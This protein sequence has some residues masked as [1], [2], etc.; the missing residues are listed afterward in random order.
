MTAT[1]SAT[2]LQIDDDLAR[3]NAL[4]LAAAQALG[5]ANAS[6][7]ISLGGLTGVYLLGDDKSLATLP[8]TAM[9]L[10]IAA[11]ALPAG[12]L[13]RRVGRR[14]GFITGAGIGFL[15]AVGATLAVVAGSFAL[16]C[17]ASFFSGIYGAFVHQ[18]RFAAADTASERFKPKAISWVMAGGILA[19]IIGPQTVIHTKDLLSPLMFAGAYV[20]QA[21]L[22]IL[23]IGVLAFLKMP[24]LPEVQRRVSGRPILTIMRQRDF[25]IAATSGICAYA[26]MNYVMTAAPLAM[27]EC[28]FTAADAALGIQWHILAMFGPSFFTGSLIAR[29]GKV[30]IVTIGFIMLAGCGV[31]ALQGIELAHFWGALILLGFGWNFAFIGATAMV[32]DTYR[33]E[34]RN[35]VQAANDF[36]V[37]GFVAIASLASGKTLNAY[38]W[39]AIN[40]LI[41][42][43][44]AFCVLLLLVSAWTGKKAS[45]G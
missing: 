39:E 17:C 16:F 25:V 29:Y 4:L 40:Y 37:F 18:Y 24:K 32:T 41:F 20:G 26:L 13:M 35:K 22:T 27:V 45:A 21:V 7:V 42:P 2:D 43:V 8:I 1:A 34:E 9:V 30:R 19:G 23:T 5:G 10:G 36:L 31:V 15:A 14:A 38:G 11:G 3:R 33:P 28:G 44:T 6:I 12:Q